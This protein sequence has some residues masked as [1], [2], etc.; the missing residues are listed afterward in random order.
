MVDRN[1]KVWLIEVNTNPCLDTSCVHLARII[2]AMLDNAFKIVLDPVFM[3]PKR[4]IDALHENR[5]ELI[6]SDFGKPQ[7]PWLSDEDDPELYEE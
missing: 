6:F 3:H 2:P 4:H 5:F 7:T 1:F